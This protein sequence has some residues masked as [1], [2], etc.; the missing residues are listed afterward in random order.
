MGTY[1]YRNGDVYNGE[2]KNGKRH[3]KGIFYNNE[4]FID[5]YW[6]NNI[7]IDNESKKEQNDSIDQEKKINLNVNELNLNEISQ[8]DDHLP[9]IT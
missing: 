5:G 9:G 1:Y 6:E 7:K 3:G 4:D 2:W 8:F